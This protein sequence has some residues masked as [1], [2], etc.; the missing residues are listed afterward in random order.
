MAKLSILVSGILLVNTIRELLLLTLFLSVL[1]F[2]SN[3]NTDLLATKLF[4]LWVNFQILLML[5][6][7]DQLWVLWYK[8]WVFNII[9]QVKKIT[10][11]LDHWVTEEQMFSFLLSHLLAGLALKTLL[12]RLRLIFSFT[13]NFTAIWL[14]HTIS[15]PCGWVSF[16]VGSR[17]ET[18]CPDRAYC[19]CGNQIRL[20]IMNQPVKSVM[21]WILGISHQ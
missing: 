17:A 19:S 6:Q 18:L 12:K 8:F 4:W 15:W 1:N 20:K 9:L 2:I 7:K 10:I 5:F 21:S 16:A 11:G 14:Y 13:L 3:L